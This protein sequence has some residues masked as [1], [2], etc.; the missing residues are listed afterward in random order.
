MSDQGRRTMLFGRHWTRAELEARSRDPSQIARVTL[1][2]LSDGVA[3]GVRPLIF[4]T[5]ADLEFWVLI[6]RVFDIAKCS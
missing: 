5:G 4:R 6:D 3:R 2:T 1:V